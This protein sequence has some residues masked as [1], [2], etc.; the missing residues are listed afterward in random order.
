MA[1]DLNADLGEG[2]GVWALGDDLGL[3]PQLS[4][5]N[6]ACGFHAG[7]PPTMQ[8]VCLAAAQA[9]VTIGAQVGYRDLIGFGRRHIDIAPAD[10]TAE[11][12][13]QAGALQA[14]ASAAGTRVRYLK[15]HG[16]LYNTAAVDPAQAAAIVDA[17]VQL[18]GQLPLLGLPDSEL[19][20]AALLRGVRFV[21]EAFADRAYLPSGQLVP[22]GEPGAVIDD[23]A[24]VV[25]RG[26]RIA[27]EQRVTAVDGTQ[28]EVNAASLCL[29]G[30][31]PGAVSLA[32]ALRAG[33][34]AAGVEVASFA[35]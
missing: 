21:A 12:V 2:F 11:I 30:D 28:I 27:T 3:L 24:E 31:T 16:A 33:L 14:F 22:R 34:E 25:A 13:Y 32:R 26:V 20:R 9:G 29:H 1:I 7:D 5:A 19:A 6:V 10:L 15:P 18:G 4:S 8:R 35:R 17:A 23:E